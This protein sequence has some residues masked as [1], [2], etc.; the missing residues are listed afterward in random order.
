MSQ[1][2]THGQLIVLRPNE[3]ILLDAKCYVFV[4]DEVN[5]KWSRKKEVLEIPH[6]DLL[7]LG[8]DFSDCIKVTVQGLF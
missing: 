3:I 5:K 7:G 6:Q 1:F 4:K 8:L 2:L